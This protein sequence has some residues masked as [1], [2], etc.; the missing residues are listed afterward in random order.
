MVSTII[1]RGSKRQ[2][3]V[4]A[5]AAV[6]AEQGFT[7]TRVA[8]IAE[9]AGIGKGTVYEYFTSKE[10][11]L[12]AVFEWIDSRVSTRVE[13]V[14]AE[15]ISGHEKLLRLLQLGADVVTEQVEMQP[16]IL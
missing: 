13:A 16:V 15:E 5:A 10:E 1:D 12:F 3:L 2:H 8:D 11:L 6:F 14:L 7:S 9:R 4:E